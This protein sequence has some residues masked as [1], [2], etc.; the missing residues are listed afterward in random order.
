MEMIKEINAEV[1]VWL[2][3]ND[4]DK[5]T[6]HKNGGKRW[7]MLTTISSESFNGLL[8]SAMGLPVT[9]MVRVTYNQI[10]NRFVTR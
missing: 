6:L 9:A 2:M 3:K 1:Y 7:G 10:G 8:K 5:W 4:L